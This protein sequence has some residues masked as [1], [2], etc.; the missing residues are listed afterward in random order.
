MKTSSTFNQ[1]KQNK[2]GKAYATQP[3]YA[4]NPCA[5]QLAKWKLQKDSASKEIHQSFYLQFDITRLEMLIQLKIPRT[6][7]KTSNG[8]N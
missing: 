8:K 3:T 1:C 7:A 6:V 2:E 4:S 5:L